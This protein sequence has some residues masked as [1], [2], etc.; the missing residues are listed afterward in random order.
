MNDNYNPRMRAMT[1]SE[2]RG[3]HWAAVIYWW[4][5]LTLSVVVSSYGNVRHA[6]TVVP[7]E[8]LTEGRWIAGSLPVVLLLMV[9]G[10]A[11]G[12][13]AG[14]AGWQRH[15]ATV[16]V[17]LLGVVVLASSYVGLLSLVQ[18]TNLFT[19]RAA[20][21]N[22]GLAAVPDL[23]MIAATVYVMSLRRPA[24][25]T[26][27]AKPAG[28][29]SRIGGNL[30]ARV[31]AATAP[32]ANTAVEMPVDPTSSPSTPP[33]TPPSSSTDEMLDPATSWA[34]ELADEHPVDTVELLPSTSPTPARHP[35]DQLVRPNDEFVTSPSTSPATSSSTPAD[36]MPV[37]LVDSPTTSTDELVD[38]VVARPDELDL[39]A[40][41]EQPDD[42][43]G[44]PVELADEHRRRAGEVVA[45]SKISAAV[46]EL[47]TVLALDADGLSKQAIADRVGRSRSTVTGWLKTV[48]D[49]TPGETARSARP[50]LVAVND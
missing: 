18:A 1:M 45:S 3:W 16:F 43:D 48:A 5:L 11:F 41:D 24:E 26:G 50:Q 33:S 25:A 27:P 19:G 44:P 13:R 10:I 32:T 9:E 28:A 12:V 36:D 40:D 29:W 14:V 35:V 8:Y 47:A 49:S 30:V 15:M 21:L 22:V 20:A 46:G 4:L 6:E 39:D 34:D 17:A 23:L 42:I 7:P 31:E 2:S 37:D 38:E